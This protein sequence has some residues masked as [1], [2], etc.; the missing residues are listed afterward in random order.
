MSL[1]EHIVAS[2]KFGSYC[3][4]A[5]SKTRPA[6]AAI[7]AGKIWEPRTVAYMTEHCGDGDIIH[8]GAYFGD[9]IPALSKGLRPGARLW[10]FEPSSENY[11]CARRT[12]E[13][14]GLE[15]TVLTH[16]G[17]G[18]RAAMGILRIGRPDLPAYGG[19][20]RFVPA[21]RKNCSH[22]DSPIVAVDEVVPEDR[23][24]S[25]LQLD[26]EGFEQQALTGALRTIARCRPKIILENLPKDAE[27]FGRAI[28][29][30]GY[31]PIA[32]VH[33]NTIFAAI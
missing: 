26:V 27:W 2:N 24:V 6:A 15:N 21:R 33:A 4:P 7:L 30:L 16:A 31:G 1:P 13:L 9:F 17:L 8:A 22:E 14:N 12:M 32:E 20:A 3:V 5:S 11:L 28:L 29:D 10:A 23:Q 18:D 25:I 19:T